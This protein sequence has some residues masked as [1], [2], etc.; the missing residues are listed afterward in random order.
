MHASYPCAQHFLFH[1]QKCTTIRD[2]HFLKQPLN[3]SNCS[4][5]VQF[6]LM[7][8][9]IQRDNTGVSYTI[10]TRSLQKRGGNNPLTCKHTCDPLWRSPYAPA[11]N[12]IHAEILKRP[13]VIQLFKHSLCF[14]KFGGSTN[15]NLST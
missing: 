13:S 3:A 2:E 8:S 11:N 9:N 5:E 10:T 14:G 6:V 7:P 12:H 1:I 4:Q 15:V